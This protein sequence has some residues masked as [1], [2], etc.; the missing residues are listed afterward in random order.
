MKR[1]AAFAVVI[2]VYA[3]SPKPAPQET[4]MVRRIQADALRGHVQFLS[5]DLLEGRDTPS[6]GLD[7]A[8]EYAAANF[9]RMGLEPLGP[10]GYF[11]T[12]VVEP[13]DPNSP[14]SRNVAAVLRGS[15]PR[16]RDS[17]VIL[18]AHYD[19]VGLAPDGD[20]R[21]FNGAN[22]DASGVASVLTAAEALAAMRPRPKRSIIF[23][24][25]C[26]E[27]KVLR[28]SRYYAL[29][30]LVPLAQTIAQLNL[31]QMGRT[32]D[33]TGRHIGMANVTGFDFSDLTQTLIRSGEGIGIKIVKDA[34]SSDRYFNRSDNAPLARAGV[35]A[36]TVSVAYDFPD[37]HKVSDT[38]DKIDYDNMANV[39]KA[40]ALTV[41]E[42]A[43]SINAPQWNANYPGAKQYVE[44]AKKLQVPAAL[45]RR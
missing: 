43:S 23:M 39:D 16:L 41:L 20:D 34:A 28:G 15:D 35:P 25:F 37:Y 42:I 9:R 11:Q 36:H 14:K 3:A 40:V 22:D 26:G 2:A 44:A 21:I 13:E 29:H 17:Y 18:S 12:V 10:E 8:G 27:E 33:S 30:P 38:W 19:H 4:S 6:R 31:E 5:S 7:I 32:D 24:L 45:Q 1:W